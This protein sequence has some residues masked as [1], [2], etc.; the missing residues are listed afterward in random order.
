MP[1]SAP[2]PISLSSMKALSRL[3]SDERLINGYPEKTGTGNNARVVVYGRAGLT[4]WADAMTLLCRGMLELDDQLLV[5]QGTTLCSYSATGVATSVGTIPGADLVI[6]ARNANSTVQVA[7][8][9]AAGVY[10]YSD[11]VTASL[12]DPDLPSGSVSVTW[13]DGYFIFALA[14]GRFFW[15]GINATTVNALDF[16]TAEANPDGLVGAAR[17][18]QEFYLFGSKSIEVWVNSGAA[19]QPFERLSG[20]T[21]QSGCSSKHTI[22]EVNGALYWLDAYGNV[23]R[24]GAGYQPELVSDRSVYDAVRAVTDK[25][26]ISALTFVLGSRYYYVL[27]HTTFTWAYDA[28]IGLWSEWRSKNNQC[29]RGIASAGW[30]NKTI[31]GSSFEGT[32]F[33]VDENSFA[34]GSDEIEFIARFPRV[35]TF[36]KGAVVS[37][38]DLDMQTGVGVAT[39]TAPDTIDPSISLYW[40]NDGGKTLKGGRIASLGKQGEYNKRV[41]FTRIGSFRQNGVIF[42]V[43]ITSK[44]FKALL[45]ARM[46]ADP[47]DLG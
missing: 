18:R 47:L 37:Q 41:R 35:D 33:Y 38:L 11:G 10:V 2:L 24:V 29:W 32:L 14:D 31:I 40:S 34:E 21:M 28:S 1:T 42:E 30:A 39:D 7:I 12:G 25:T 23:M 5:L 17:L 8:V 20:A 13:L 43:R 16:A 9:C 19:S 6:M 3:A 27:T 22:R 46:L 45:G 44:V 36:P 4:I 15:S 26:S